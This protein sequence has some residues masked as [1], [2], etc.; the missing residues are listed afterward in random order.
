[1]SEAQKKSQGKG[2]EEFVTNLGKII[3][4]L[5]RISWHGLLRKI[6]GDIDRVLGLI[7]WLSLLLAL[8]YW[9]WMYLQFLH[10]CLPGVFTVGLMSFF[11][12]HVPRYIQFL[13]LA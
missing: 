10:W 13:G 11:V 3:F 5:S 8:V 7:A 2:L 4:F 1:M 9:D 12:Y 6:F